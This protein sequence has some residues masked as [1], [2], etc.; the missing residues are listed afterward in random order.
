VRVAEG[1]EPFDGAA[2]VPWR[3]D[4]DEID[5]RLRRESRHRRRAD[6]LD[7]ESELARRGRSS[8]AQP[9]ELGRPA[10]VVV[11]DDDRIRH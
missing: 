10:W 1:L 9:L 3:D 6:V 11:H 2:H 8:I 7:G 5:H 4:H